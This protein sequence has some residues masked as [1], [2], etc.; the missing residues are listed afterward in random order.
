[1]KRILQAIHAVDGVQGSLV[2]DGNGQLLAHQA[3]AV[4][5]AD[6]MGSVGQTI[7][8][9]M[10]SI[11]LL[12]EDWETLSASF[13][14]GA[15]ILRNVKPEGA[16]AGRPVIL[17]IIGDNRLN[18]SFAGVAMRV[19]AT[20]LKAHLDQMASGAAQSHPFSVAADSSSGPAFS[21]SGP[22]PGSPSATS[23]MGASGAHPSRP[24][25]LASSG[26]SWSGIGSS[27]K[28]ISEPL[29]AD[30]ES[31]AFMA[32]TS[33]ALSSMLGPMAKVFVKES[34]RKLCFDR[35]FSRAQW[36]ALVSDV[37]KHIQDPA[38]AAQFQN[39]MRTRM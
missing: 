15:I 7:V 39:A 25:D 21:R 31:A 26:V 20:K 22:V 33:K 2:V 11:R 1:M 37:G 10:D 13:A 32:A 6:L 29:P 4:Y 38:H 12:H 14:E 8:S 36:G 35:P 17:G 9:T 28:T 3:H 34:I 27:S 5:D 24:N 16:A 18:T 30:P 19:A 23:S